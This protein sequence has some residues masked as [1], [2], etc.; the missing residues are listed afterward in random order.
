MKLCMTVL[1]IFI[2]LYYILDGPTNGPKHVVGI[3][4]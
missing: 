4:T 1:Y 3:I 2:Y